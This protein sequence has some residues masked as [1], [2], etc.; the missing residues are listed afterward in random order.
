MAEITDL[1]N[2]SFTPFP[3]HTDRT[4]WRP[5]GLPMILTVPHAFD[6]DGFSRP[7][8]QVSN[9]T[10]FIAEAAQN[11]VAGHDN[12]G[13]FKPEIELFSKT[14]TQTELLERRIRDEDKI[15]VNDDGEEDPNGR[16]FRYTNRIGITDTLLFIDHARYYDLSDILLDIERLPPDRYQLIYSADYHP[17]VI[18]KDIVS[19]ATGFFCIDDSITITERFAFLLK[20]PGEVLLSTVNKTPSLYFEGKKNSE[21]STIRFYRPFTDILQDIHDEQEF[22]SR[23][24]LVDDVEPQL[25]PYLASLLGWE[26]PYH[27]ESLDDLRREFIKNI[28][29]LQGLKGTKR[30]VRE[31]FDLFGFGINL[32]HVWWTPDGSEFV[33]EGEIDS[34]NTYAIEVESTSTLEPLFADFTQP[35]FGDVTIPITNRPID[36]VISVDAF[37]VEDGSDAD[38]ALQQIADNLSNDLSFYDS[39]TQLPL[40]DL[41]FTDL[42]N[43]GKENGIVGRSDFTINDTEIFS[44]DSSDKAP[45]K[46]KGVRFNPLEN[47]LEIVFDR[48]LD[49]EGTTLY[50]FVSYAYNRIIVPD[51]MMDLR[52]NRFDVS[53]NFKGGDTVGNNIVE[54][55]IGFLKK[56]K[57]F[58]SLLRKLLIT[59]D[60]LD[61]V[62]QVTDLCF[63][64]E[65]G[66]E[67][68]CAEAVFSFLDSLD[69]FTRRIVRALNGEFAAWK[70]L[71]RDCEFTPRGQDRIDNVP[72]ETTQEESNGFTFQKR[73]VPDTQCDFTP[74]FCFKGRVDDEVGHRYQ[75]QCDDE[76]QLNLCGLTMGTGVYYL[77]VGDEY[78]NF[79][80]TSEYIM[81]GLTKKFNNLLG[82]LYRKYGAAL[83]TS[84][85]YSNFKFLTDETIA[86]RHLALLRPTSNIKKDNLNFPGHR[87]PRLNAL[88][89]DFESEIYNMRPWDFDLTCD[90]DP[91]IDNQLNA[92][93]EPDGDDETIVFDEEPYFVEG[94]GLKEDIPSFASTD[95]NELNFDVENVTSLLYLSQTSDGHPAVTLDN[96]IEPDEEFFVP[97]TA[98]YESAKE[99]GNLIYDIKNG[100]PAEVD[101]LGKPKETAIISGDGFFIYLSA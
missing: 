97:D 19:T 7:E 85:H 25:F 39:E 73:N 93:L 57:A 55:L 94:N 89:E 67:Q 59:I 43:A 54:F 80:P 20:H 42:I 35:G 6:E 17:R 52:S 1:A 87:L 50:A 51:E 37:L 72:R 84:I 40:R 23:I 92:R 77:I 18:D 32:G 74:D 24:N 31:L 48:H 27:P 41:S 14:L 101:I 12:V 38:T 68:G 15:R 61:D 47:N 82:D 28:A 91:E 90:C 86:K 65:I 44:D 69:P 21:D 30:V 66:S 2:P 11:P 4:A 13:V 34:T 70:E 58:H 79:D 36:R 78:R 100:Y 26:L 5:Y 88:E 3:F 64:I 45:I 62:Y 53:I 99:C 76:V 10:V 98:I 56:V 83:E 9:V 33:G 63:D 81:A 49:F 96:V 46:A 29:K 95:G 22:I 8:A 60:D 16:L 75:A 71:D